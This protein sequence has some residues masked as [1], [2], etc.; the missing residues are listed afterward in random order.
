[1]EGSYE[2]IKL[3]LLA[4][5]DKL[6]AR[7]ELAGHTPSDYFEPG[8]ME[9]LDCFEGLYSPETGDITLRFEARGTRYDGRTEQ[10]EKVRAGDEVVIV[11]DRDNK[12]N[13]NNFTMETLRGKNI[14]NMPAELCNVMAPLY[15]A[16]LLEFTAS[17]VSYVEPLSKRSRYAKQ[18]VLFVELRG[19]LKASSDAGE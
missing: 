13:P 15:D 19:L 11:R 9:N 7:R 1:M 8:M 6:H 5:L 12:Y 10:I 3:K 17:E 18:A 2:G 16:G 4:E 14:G